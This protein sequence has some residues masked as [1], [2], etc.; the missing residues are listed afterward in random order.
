M[1][2]LRGLLTCFACLLILSACAPAFAEVSVR[3]DRNG[4]YIATQVFYAGVDDALKK[5]WSPRGRG[6]RKVEV[7]NEFGD[8]NGDLWPEIRESSIAPHYPLVV[9]SRFSGTEFDLA[10]ST[11]TGENW[12]TVEWVFGENE[13][14]DDLDPDLVF[15]SQGQAYL[16]WW[17]DEDGDGRV[18]LSTLLL[19]RW[20][21]PLLVSDVAVN[22]RYP[23]IEVDE[24][25]LLT[26]SYETS[27]GTV[28]K[29]VAF[30]Y[31]DTITDDAHP[32]ISINVEVRQVDDIGN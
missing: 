30:T 3:T 19:S 23:S 26:V 18:Y 10:W 16:V 24:K 32:Q 5:V 22:S 31:P 28:V 7:L 14:G 9:W 20:T 6:I 2:M 29:A 13:A 25:D 1:I 8:A 4:D 15:D 27:D 12:R 17:R 21:R 11:W